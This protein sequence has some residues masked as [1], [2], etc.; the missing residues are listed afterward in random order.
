MGHS[1]DHPH[2]AAI[3]IGLSQFA[4]TQVGGGW[5]SEYHFL[6]RLWQKKRIVIPCDYKYTV[7]WP[8]LSLELEYMCLRFFMG[9]PWRTPNVVLLWVISICRHQLDR[10][11]LRKESC[12]KHRRRYRNQHQRD[13]HNRSCRQLSQTSPRVSESDNWLDIAFRII[14]IVIVNIANIIRISI[15][16]ILVG[17]VV[18]SITD[19]I[20]IYASLVFLC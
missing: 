18:S 2:S 15:S 4:H 3:E 17:Q 1:F 5:R 14:R 11:C 6:V 12:R 9:V 19:A 16:L 20:I 10:G 7:S 13:P 8:W